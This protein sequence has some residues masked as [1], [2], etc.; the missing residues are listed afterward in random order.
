MMMIGEIAADLY[1]RTPDSILA[2]LVEPVVT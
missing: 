1:D 2:N